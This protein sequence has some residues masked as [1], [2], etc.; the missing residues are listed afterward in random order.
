MRDMETRKYCP[1]LRSPV[2]T[3]VPCQG[4]MCMAW[5]EENGYCKL[6]DGTQ[7]VWIVRE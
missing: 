2:T 4:T 5:D 3:L 1:F 7:N 6:I